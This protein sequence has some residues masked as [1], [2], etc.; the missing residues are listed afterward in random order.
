MK[1]FVKDAAAKVLSERAAGYPILNLILDDG[2]NKYSN[3]GGSCAIGDSFQIVASSET[4]EDFSNLLESNT[5]FIFFSSKDELTFWKNGL[6]LDYKG[7]NFVLKDDTGILDSA[8]RF[9]IA[10]EQKPLSKQ[11]MVKMSQ[12]IC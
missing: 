4:D 10:N 8:V 2:S 3:L 7:S 12:M 11:E 1:L 6:T 5:D 9:S